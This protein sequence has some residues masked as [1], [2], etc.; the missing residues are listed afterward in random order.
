MKRL[1]IILS[2]LSLFVLT[3]GIFAQKGMMQRGGYRMVQM[4]DL[5]DAQQSKFQDL[6]LDL[7]KEI[8]PLRSKM[9]NLH[10]ELRMQM[11]AEKFDQGKVDNILED[12]EDL[13]TQIHSKRIQHHRAIRD[14]LTP[15]QQKKFDLHVLSGKRF[16]RGWG[17][18]HGFG[19]GKGR[20]FGHGPHG[21]HFGDCPRF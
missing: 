17:H 19:P 5:T 20:G 1:M 18:G 6:R 15:E 21:P 4:L 2:L 14:M 8:A 10:S 3:T 16:G 13:R 7:E 12:M 11:A 9:H